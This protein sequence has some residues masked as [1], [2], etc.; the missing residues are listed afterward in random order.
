MSRGNGLE[1]TFTFDDNN[2]AEFWS[3]AVSFMFLS[4]GV[5]HS[6]GVDTQMPI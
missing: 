6:F 2:P 5:R 3:C 4:Q 1:D